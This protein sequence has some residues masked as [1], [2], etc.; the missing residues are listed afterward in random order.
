MHFLFKKEITKLK[1][2]QKEIE[3]KKAENAAEP[4]DMSWCEVFSGGLTAEF[5]PLG[6]SSDS[7]ASI[8]KLVSR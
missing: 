8:L 3:R 2:R 7:N 4:V 1:R 5:F 6:F